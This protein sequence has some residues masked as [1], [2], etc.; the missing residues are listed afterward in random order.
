MLLVM[1]IGNSNIKNGLFSDGVLRHSWRFGTKPG[2]TADEYGV[3]M[4]SIFRHLEISTSV[5]EGIII[6]SVNPSL[7]YTLD[8]MCRLY[9]PR[10]KTS[11]VNCN[12]ELGLEILYDIPAQLGTDRICNAVAAYKEYGA[13]ITV[14][15]G[16]ASTYTVVN[17]KGQLLGGLICP[18]ILVSTE[19]LVNKAAMLYKVEFTKP[20]RVIGRNT[21]DAMQ[22]GLI[23]G[24]VG[25][26]EYIVRQIKA[27]LN[28]PCT[29]V[30]TG[31]MSDSIARETKSI[32]VV[33]PTLTLEGL[34]EI[35]RMNR[36]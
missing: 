9:F 28:S 3:Q 11:F 8:H 5:V 29:V 25:Q 2:R 1:D 32:D 22:S 16:T 31:G 30:A 7:N 24:F 19:A 27:E 26:V 4:E 12:M 35:Y 17:E 18:G 33:N 20:E 14:D 21:V 23:H 10:A 34:Y 15:F 36:P 13:S 6:S